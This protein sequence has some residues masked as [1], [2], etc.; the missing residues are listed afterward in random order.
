MVYLSG[1]EC[2]G[3]AQTLTKELSLAL[4][5]NRSLHKKWNGLCF[6]GAMLERLIVRKSPCMLFLANLCIK[7]LLENLDSLSHILSLCLICSFAP[8]FSE[9]I[10]YMN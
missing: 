4:H 6:L 8:H 1:T 3:R 9:W 10:F 7:K 5:I 2:G